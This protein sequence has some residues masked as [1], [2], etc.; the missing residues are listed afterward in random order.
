MLRL[1]VVVVLDAS[2][3]AAINS[4]YR[5]RTGGGRRPGRRRGSSRDSADVG[6]EEKRPPFT[7]AVPTGPPATPLLALRD[8][9]PT[10]PLPHRPAS[11]WRSQRTGPFRGKR[12]GRCTREGPPTRFSAGLRRHCLVNRRGVCLPPV[13]S[14]ADGVSV[15]FAGSAHDG[16][17]RSATHAN[18]RSTA[19]D[20]LTGPPSAERL[21]P[22]SRQLRWSVA[23]AG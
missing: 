5:S 3:R 4:Q 23:P 11:S 16:R 10:S 22:V 17:R 15:D 13:D 14:V 21:T 7:F 1:V 9:P 6:S 2:H 8:R 12:W 18:A 19:L 20:R